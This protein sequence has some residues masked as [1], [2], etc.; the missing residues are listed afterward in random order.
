MMK[1]ILV[2]LKTRLVFRD[3]RLW[4]SA[5]VS[6]VFIAGCDFLNESA[7]IGPFGED[8]RGEWTQM[9]DMYNVQYYY[10][11]RLVR[12]GKNNIEGK[13]H[14][15]DVTFE[16]GYYSS[17]NSSYA[18]DIKKITRVSDHVI[19]VINKN[20]EKTLLFSATPPGLDSPPPVSN[21]TVTFYR[22]AGSSSSESYDALYSV[23]IVPGDAV[24]HFQYR[25]NPAIRNNELYATVPR[26]DG[27]YIFVFYGKNRTYSIGI[28]QSADTDFSDF[29]DDEYAVPKNTEDSAARVTGQVQIKSALSPNEI[30]WDFFKVSLGSGG[31]FF[32]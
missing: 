29:V 32:E 13:V 22:S 25:Y 10:D 26:I 24:Y 30:D 19:E 3:A 21:K 27:E 5:L 9:L 18:E 12:I 8:V 1:N 31:G 2:S 20:S 28:D 17:A 15:I 4:F 23:I 14:F 7:V 6:V 11:A 16:S